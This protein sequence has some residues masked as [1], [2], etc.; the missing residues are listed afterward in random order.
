MLG[1]LS[2]ESKEPTYYNKDNTI[3]LDIGNLYA[4]MDVIDNVRI[5]EAIRLRP[6]VAIVKGKLE[7]IYFND[8]YFSD[9]AVSKK[10]EPNVDLKAEK[11]LHS[12]LQQSLEL[13]LMDAVQSTH[14]PIVPALVLLPLSLETLFK[15]SF[16][17][18]NF[19]L[20]SKGLRLIVGLS[21]DDVLANPVLYE[22]AKGFL[23]TQHHKILLNSLTAD[24]LPYID[25]SG[26]NLDFV[27]ITWSEKLPELINDV[28]KVIEIVG[29]NKVILSGCDTQD[30]VEWGAKLGIR[31]F[32]GD[33]TDA[34]I[35]DYITKACVLSKCTAAEC[36]SRYCVFSGV[37]RERCKYPDVMNDPP[38]W[39]GLF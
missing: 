24:N 25:I 19:G 12:Y 17:I 10:M 29:A 27:K 3:P 13:K 5:N 28:K 2:T 7:G 6:I 23:K 15:E 4:V 14:N 9:A 33:Y 16:D 32:E 39:I 37:L 21:V 8:F 22:Q 34:L 30:T 20:K 26:M 38:V 31:F 1:K 11:W 36:M 35:G 18:F